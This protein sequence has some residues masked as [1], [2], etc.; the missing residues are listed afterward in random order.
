M[1]VSI[2]SNQMLLVTYTYLAGIIA[3][4][5]KCLLFNHIPSH[6]AM[7]KYSV[8]RLKFCANA[9][10]YPWFLV[11]VGVNS[12]SGNTHMVGGEGTNRNDFIVSF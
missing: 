10:V 2:E 4:I 12:H 1:H 7:V 5:A 11:W 3:G 8:S 6:L 9:A